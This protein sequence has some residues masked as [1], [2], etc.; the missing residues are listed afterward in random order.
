MPRPP[1]RVLLFALVAVA[2]IAYAVWDNA[3]DEAPAPLP[4]E[5]SGGGSGPRERTS[6][7]ARMIPPEAADR[8]SGAG[9]A[10]RN[11]GELA[12]RLP[13]ERKVAQ[14]FVWG[15]E[16]Q[17]LT[18]PIYERLRALD[19][20]GILIRS[21]NYLGPAQLAAQSGEAVVISQQE[22]HV[23][24]WVFAS[25]EGAEFSSFPDL[26]PSG[27]PAD[28]ETPEGAAAAAGE[29]ADALRPLGVTALLGPVLDVGTEDGGAVG[30]RA[31]ADEAEAVAAYGRDVIEEYAEAGVLAA[32]KHFPGL[33]A[34][35]QDTAAG[36]ASVGLTVDELGRRDLVP[37]RAAVRAGTPALTI[38]HGLYATDDFV[39]PA[40]LSPT[41][42][43]ELLRGRLRFRGVAVTDDLAAPA[44]TAVMS[45]PDAAVAALDAGADQLVI[46]GPLGEQEAAYTAVLNAVRR[47]DVSVRQVDVAVTR[48]LSAKRD[49]GLIAE[50]RAAAPAQGAQPGP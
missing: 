28:Y 48:I 36:P 49:L 31:F 2:A 1:A 39:T 22:G 4:P 23:P 13:L 25:Q 26:P 44:V 47:G 33:G 21:R 43:D 40:S 5:A 42:A 12:R 30:A 50:D 32:P 41:I 14:L 11:V 45:V 7:L 35:N 16:G 37:F 20:G 18:D 3:R 8:R 27:A 15:F 6:F 34:A 38:G 9:R 46:S 10:P 19:L 24:P 17:D 29:A